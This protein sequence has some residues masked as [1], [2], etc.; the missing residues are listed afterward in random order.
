MAPKWEVTY[1]KVQTTQASGVFDQLYANG[2]MQVPLYIE[3]KAIDPTNNQ[4]YTLT[5]SELNT[6]QLIDYWDQGSQLSG[7]WFYSDQENE[8]DHALDTSSLT[9]S[10][11]GPSIDASALSALTLSNNRLAADMSALSRSTSLTTTD[12]SPQWKCF[13]VSTEKVE[14]K[15]IGASITQPDGSRVTTHSTDFDSRVTL[16]GKTPIYYNTETISKVKEK[17][18]KGNWRLRVK[19]S[20]GSV[21]KDLYRDWHQENH[22]ITSKAHPF[23]KADLHEYKGGDPE[24][25]RQCFWYGATDEKNLKL[26][27]IWAYGV[28]A[29]KELGQA[30]VIGNWEINALA[31]VA[32]NERSHALCLTRLAVDAYETIWDNA[33]GFA[34][35]FRFFDVYGNT[36]DF[37]VDPSDDHEDIKIRNKN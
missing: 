7:N 26:F 15:N 24:S 18:S 2:R 8:F 30:R 17:T 34:C 21:N 29:K 22:Y 9:L 11:S 20:D 10:T 16:T 31:N 28:E 6:I 5:Q 33:W 12:S 25:L 27:Y 1:L 36:G 35:W 4:R 23:K 3:I 19:N 32:L 14:N 37:W 13:W